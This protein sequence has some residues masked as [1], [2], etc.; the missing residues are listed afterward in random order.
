[1]KWIKNNIINTL[2]SKFLIAFC[3]MGVVVITSQTLGAEGRGAISYVL[4]IITIA[5][6]L[7]EFVGG[8]ALINL[9]P[10][11]RIVNL[12][13]PSYVFSL[14]VALIL[15]FIM[16]GEHDLLIPS[17][18]MACIALFLCLC[19]INLNLILGRQLINQRNAIQFIYTL[20]L[21]SGVYY[22]Y[23]LDGQRE[24]Q[25][26]FNMLAF[27]YVIG[28]ILSTLQLFRIADKGNPEPIKWVKEIFQF[29]FWSQLSQL[30]NL[31]NYRIAYFFVEHDFGLDQLGIY[32]NGMTVGDMMKIPGQSLGQVQHNRII[33]QEK[34][35]SHHSKVL[36]SRYLTLNLILYIGQAAVIL[37]IP[38]VFWT[39][40]L[41][42][43][44]LSLKQV[45]LY[46]LPG[47][48]ALGIATSFSYYFHAVNQFRTVLLVN[49]ITLTIFVLGYFR[50]T[51]EYGF[52][53][54]LISFSV[55]YVIQLFCFVVL[56]FLKSKG[57]F[58]PL[59]DLRY[60]IKSLT[61]KA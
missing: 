15:F 18:L 25:P 54:V 59:D 40:L 4:F 34:L 33:N 60:W 1:M 24:I 23:G 20:L 58:K 19:N 13:W 7:A 9:A 17:W 43:D 3:M 32:S 29:G 36:T 6:V 56:F 47:F 48:V 30:I 12:I 57:R 26:Y 8:S 16:R 35:D 5:Q 51:H 52:M 27:T 45:I 53:A 37:L 14:I 44:F 2:L 41:G 46:M 22:V 42:A 10:K 39:W 49:I 38:A 55:A 28:F 61:S 50:L 21:L 11:E 31:L